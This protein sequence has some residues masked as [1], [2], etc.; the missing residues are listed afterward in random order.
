MAADVAGLR[1]ARGRHLDDLPCLVD[2][3]PFQ[4]PAAAGQDVPVEAGFLLHVTARVLECPWRTWSWLLCSGLPAPRCGPCPAGGT[5]RG[6][7][8]RGYAPA[9]DAVCPGG[10]RCGGCRCHSQRCG[11]RRRPPPMSTSSGI[12]KKGVMRYRPQRRGRPAC[13]WTDHNLAFA[14]GW[15]GPEYSSPTGSSID[16]GPKKCTKCY[17]NTAHRFLAYSI[18]ICHT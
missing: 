5:L 10:G 11:P 4:L 6:L 7:S 2:Q 17:K 14:W 12:T 18:V 8:R 1:R 15:V 3:P 16:A 13:S 9:S